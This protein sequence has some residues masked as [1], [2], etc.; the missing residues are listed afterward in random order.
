M[1]GPTV[2]IA[3]L[4][5][6]CTV[7]GPGR[8]FVV[9]VQGCP[10]N[11][12][13]CVSPQWIPARGGRVVPVA[14]LA[15]RIIAEAADGLTLSGGEPFAQA[16]ALVRLVE[17]VRRRRDLSVLSYSGYTIEHLRRHGTPDQHRLLDRLDL[18]I[19]GPYRPDRHADLLWRGSDNQRIHRLTDRHADLPGAAGPGAGLQFEVGADGSLRWMG[20]PPVPGFRRR[21]EQAMGSP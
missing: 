1:T 14:E 18:L 19:D 2:R 17:T 9:W 5:P 10:L 16:D 12:R 13:D 4:H 15:D 21:L 20:V 6:S 11:C 7:L 8:R 3:A